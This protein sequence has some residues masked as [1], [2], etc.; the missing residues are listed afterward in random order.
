MCVVFGVFMHVW[1]MYLVCVYIRCGCS[2]CVCVC[3]MVVCVRI[4]CM[5]VV[6]CLIIYE[7]GSIWGSI[8][9]GCIFGVL[10]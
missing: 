4:L 5:C 8:C 6:W 10:V 7:C 1:Y 2:V 9:M 3:G